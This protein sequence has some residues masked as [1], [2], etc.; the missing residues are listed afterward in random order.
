MVKLTSEVI[1]HGYQYM[2]VSKEYELSLRG[3]KIISIQNLSATNDQFGSIDLSDNSISKVEE[4]NSLN[5]LRSLLL[6]NNRITYIEN[7]FAINCPKLENLILTN[8]KISDIEVIDNISSCKTLLRLSLMNNLVTKLKYYRL[9]VIYKM[10]NLRVLDFQK[11]KKIEKEEAMRLFESE[12]GEKI[13]ENIRNKNFSEDDK[14][15]KKGLENIKNNE[16]VH[17]IIADKIKNTNNYDELIN[18]KKKITTGEIVDEIK[19]EEDEKEKEIE[20][21]NEKDDKKKSKG[22]TKSKGKGKRKK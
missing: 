5:R 22:K 7:D 13:I 17:K 12:E 11:V 19:K 15:F 2:N 14:E 1:S 9:Y 8:N 3:F 10:P 16:K 6:I 18:I 20:I 4:L 21:D